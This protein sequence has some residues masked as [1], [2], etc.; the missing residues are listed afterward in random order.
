MKVAQLASSVAYE[1]Q[2]HHGEQGISGVICNLAQDFTGANNLNWL[3]PI[4]QFGSRLSPV[5]AAARAAPP[6]PFRRRGAAH[7]RGAVRGGVGFRRS[8]A[9]RCDRARRCRRCAPARSPTD[10]PVVSFRA[11]LD[12]RTTAFETF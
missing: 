5:P 1:T 4:G 7:R 8:R 10:A 9:R 12:A 6:A 11:A 3:E 2:Y